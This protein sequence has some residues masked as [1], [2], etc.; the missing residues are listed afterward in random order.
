METH[1]GALQRQDFRQRKCVNPPKVKL[2]TDL[3]GAID[4]WE[5]DVRRI[6]NEYGEI[7]GKGLKRAVLVETLPSS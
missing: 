1:G 4:K 5:D 7:L 3:P 6:Q 2:P